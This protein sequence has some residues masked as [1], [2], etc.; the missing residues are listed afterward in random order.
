MYEVVVKTAKG[1]DLLNPALNVWHVAT[2]DD[3]TTVVSQITMFTANSMMAYAAGGAGIIGVDAGTLGDPLIPFAVDGTQIGAWQ[4]ALAGSGLE[5]ADFGGYGS[6]LGSGDPLPAGTS[7]TLM[8]HTALG[9][10]HNGRKY[11]PYANEA[12]CVGGVLDA[13][14]AQTIVWSYQFWIQG[15][16][17]FP[18]PVLP[19]DAGDLVPVA[20]ATNSPIGTIYCSSAFSRLRSRQR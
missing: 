19:A 3:L 8:E 10:R 9:G 12:S 18:G 4:T 16:V 20:G 13:T 11:L 14:I 15:I 17:P 7:V 5:A 6:D 2:T 1:T